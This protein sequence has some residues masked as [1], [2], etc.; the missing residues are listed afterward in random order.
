M[1]PLRPAGHEVQ[2]WSSRAEHTSCLILT[3]ACEPTVRLVP[4]EDRFAPI[5]PHFDSLGLN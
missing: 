2:T 4:Q 1:T 5:V 3:Q